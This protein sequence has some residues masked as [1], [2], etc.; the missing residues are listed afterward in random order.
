MTCALHGQDNR[1]LAKFKRISPDRLQQ[2]MRQPNGI[3][4]VAKIL[5]YYDWHDEGEVWGIAPRNGCQIEP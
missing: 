5:G 2:L 1:A 4:E 3:E